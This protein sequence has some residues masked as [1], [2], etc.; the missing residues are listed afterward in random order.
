MGNLKALCAAIAMVV[1]IPVV[2]AGMALAVLLVIIT[3]PL[4]IYSIL[5]GKH[6]KDPLTGFIGHTDNIFTNTA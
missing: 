4:T 1:M 3:S 2:I 5:S 6:L